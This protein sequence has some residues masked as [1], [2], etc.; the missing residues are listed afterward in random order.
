MPTPASEAYRQLISLAVHELRTPIGVVS[1][2]LRMLLR[3]T[4]EPLTPRQRKMID[5]ADKS[6][7]RMA[8]MIAE[9]SDVGK[10]DAGIITLA[11]QSLDLV[12]LIA[13]V[14]SQVHE[15]SD[16]DVHL[17]LRGDD[18]AAPVIG[19]PG[20]LRTAFDAIF[21]GVLREKPGPASM[22]ADCRLTKIDGVDWLV[23]VVAE[24]RHVDEALARPRRPF[25]E[26]RGG[27]G[28]A[29]PLARRVFE[30]HRGGLWSPQPGAGRTD[31]DDPLSRSSAIIAIPLADRSARL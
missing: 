14:V 21:R 11:Q 28:L 3:D 9:L 23:V 4:D 1:G 5:E 30:G 18:V 20:R 17:T 13:E 6:C 12:P 29:L 26:T 7:M 25:V 22:V 8:A 15:A 16:R 10:L 27:M 24:A 31:A 2:Y 19:D